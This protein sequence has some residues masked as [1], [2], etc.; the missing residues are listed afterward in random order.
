[1]VIVLPT[2][3]T[4]RLV[5]GSVKDCGTVNR[6]VPPAGEWRPEPQSTGPSTVGQVTVQSTPKFAGSP[7]TVAPKFKTA[8]AGTVPGK[9]V[10]MAI[11][12]TVD[13]MVTETEELLLLSV[14]DSAVTVTLFLEGTPG[15]AV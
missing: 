11:P 14:V 8:P 10:V 2:T 13:V 5:T 4:G 1:M 12:V 9:G 7:Y 6:I 3:D 15:G